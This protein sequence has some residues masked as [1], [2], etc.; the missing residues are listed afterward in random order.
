[1]E[2]CRINITHSCDYRLVL[3][4]DLHPPYQICMRVEAT[5]GECTRTV[6]VHVGFR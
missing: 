3:V 4:K 1:M 2:A 5:N 6:G